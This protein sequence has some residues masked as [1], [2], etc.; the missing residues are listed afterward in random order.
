MGV[1]NVTPDSFSDGGQYYDRKRHPRLAIEQGRALAAA[2]ADLV[3]VGGE[4]TRPGAETVPEDEELRRVVPVVE[5]LAAEGG[6]VSIDTSK[7]AVAKAAV[8]AGAAI[9]NDVSGG[10]LDAALLGTVAELGVPYVLMHMRGTPRT[11]Q[12]DPVYADVVA[13]VFDFLGEGLE[14]CVAAGIDPRLVV[15]DPG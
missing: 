2:G 9:V 8:E 13:E 6:L 11:M 1:L 14:R 7:S 5:A 3:D 4:S 10:S 12:C 15:V